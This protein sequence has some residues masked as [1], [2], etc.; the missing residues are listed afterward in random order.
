MYA[1]LLAAFNNLRSGGTSASQP[2][3]GVVV[4]GVACQPYAI[5]DMLA[6]VSWGWVEN[7]QTAS[8]CK[9][10]RLC[11]QVVTDGNGQKLHTVV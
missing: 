10:H 8:F 3:L 11:C 4:L 6:Q 5:D 1:E 9:S 2:R 7:F